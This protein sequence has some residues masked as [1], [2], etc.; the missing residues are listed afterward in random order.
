[1]QQEHVLAA[2]IAAATAVRRAQRSA[3][4]FFSSRQHAVPVPPPGCAA[5]PSFVAGTRVCGYQIIHRA[6][7]AVENFDGEPVPENYQEPPIAVVR[8]I[9]HGDPDAVVTVARQLGYTSATAVSSFEVD[10]CE[11]E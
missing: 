10:L 6:P 11:L 3:R 5:L 7:C 9:V 1:M 4:A 8:A 2:D